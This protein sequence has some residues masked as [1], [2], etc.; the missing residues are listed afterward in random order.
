MFDERSGMH[1]GVVLIVED[2]H[3]VARA[4]TRMLPGELTRRVAAN[5][6]TAVNM[7][8]AHSDW[9]LFLIDVALGEDGSGLDV[10]DVAIDEHP[11]VVRA[12]VT[13]DATA[14]VN[15]Y[16][17]A[18]WTDVIRKPF[19]RETL[20][21]TLARVVSLQSSTGEV[22]ER[23]ASLAVAIGLSPREHELLGRL[24]AGKKRNELPETMGIKKS[25]VDTYVGAIVAKMQAEDI[26]EVVEDLL[27]GCPPRTHPERRRR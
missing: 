17:R 13:A 1:H 6:T 9:A 12:L 27:R 20:A 2:E 3:V 4:L 21:P 16:A 18:R 11:S 24:V 22:A 15:N 8:R 26:H 14:R 7:L 10:L 5:A 23:L 19:D 25:T